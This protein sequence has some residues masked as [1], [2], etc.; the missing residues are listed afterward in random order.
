MKIEEKLEKWK[1]ESLF[2][3]RSYEKLAHSLYKG[4]A[5]Y[6]IKMDA[7]LTVEQNTKHIKKH[8]LF[9]TRVQGQIDNE[10]LNKSADEYICQQIL[11]QL[12]TEFFNEYNSFIEE[13][14]A[15]IASL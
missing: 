2:G 15:K 11:T 7:V 14:V 5:L 12:E 4:E 6:L 10:T 9:Q 13:E 3:E 8:K 1:D